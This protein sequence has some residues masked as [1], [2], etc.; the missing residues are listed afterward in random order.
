M[1]VSQVAT[2]SGNWPARNTESLHELYTGATR[3]MTRIDPQQ[4]GVKRIG[5]FGF[6]HRPH[7]DSLWQVNRLPAL[8]RS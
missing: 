2:G 8:Q 6:F 5:H 4:I 1:G 3:T 7:A